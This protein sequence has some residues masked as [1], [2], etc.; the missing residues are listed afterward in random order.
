MAIIISSKRANIVQMMTKLTPLWY[1]VK[2]GVQRMESA[3]NSKTAPV[4]M[5]DTSENQ[6]L[7]T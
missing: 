2:D 5:T 7:T 6:A 4:E 3:I 1:A